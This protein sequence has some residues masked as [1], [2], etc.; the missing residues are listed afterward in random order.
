MVINSELLTWYFLIFS[1]FYNFLAIG[2]FVVH[3]LAERR[4]SRE[5]QRQTPAVARRPLK[6]LSIIIPARDEELVIEATVR[7]LLAGLKEGLKGVRYELIV[8]DDASEDSTPSILA[9]L[10]RI[11]GKKLLIAHREL[12]NSR[13][14]KSEALNAAL[15]VL[16]KRFRRRKKENWVVAVFDAD[17]TCEPS[18]FANVKAT[19]EEMD[20]DA[21]Q[22][23]VRIANAGQHWLPELQDIEMLTFSGF[24][25]AVRGLYAR[26]VTLGGNAQFVRME[27]LDS[28]EDE[29]GNTWDP[30]SLTEDLDLGMKLHC[31]GARIAFCPEYVSQQGLDTLSG[32]LRQRNRWAWGTIQ[33]CFWYLPSGRFW[34][35]TIPFYRKVDIAY[36]LTFWLMP[37]AVATTWIIILLAI[38]TDLMVAN[39][40][41]TLFLSVVSLSYLPLFAVGAVKVYSLRRPRT[42]LMLALTVLYTYHWVPAMMRGLVCVVVGITPEW[43]KTGRVDPSVYAG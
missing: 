42:W 21:V 17:A 20:A 10:A 8:V 13:Q 28:V 32:L 38:F 1:T 23:G 22:C 5:D 7:S 31:L 11:Y 2:L 36:Y 14:G 29:A 39:R 16:K 27:S 6:Y 25:Q 41:G 9:G 33:T 24:M 43:S 4:V 15:R 35:S 26:S 40:F 12:P 19:F 30:R 37:I 18:L 34:R 3:R